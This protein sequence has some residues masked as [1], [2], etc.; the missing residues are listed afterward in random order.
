M[1]SIEDILLLRAQQEA[2]ERPTGTQAAL[3][4]AGLG[5]AGGALIGNIPHQAG[6]AINAVTNRTPNR[7][8]GG[9]RLAGGLVGGGLGAAI[10][11]GDGRWWA[12]P[13]GAVVG[14]HIGCDAAGG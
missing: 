2:A 10:S 4:G 9:T 12:I 1:P 7:L 14:S 13:L 11:R 5:A 3:L 6:R 8:K